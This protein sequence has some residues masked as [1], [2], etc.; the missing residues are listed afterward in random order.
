MGPVRSSN[1]NS[2]IIHALQVII[3]VEVSPRAPVIRVLLE[4]NALV[5][6]PMWLLLPHA[7][8]GITAPAV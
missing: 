8:S 5:E 3:G 6:M 7:L 1:F 2:F 4:T